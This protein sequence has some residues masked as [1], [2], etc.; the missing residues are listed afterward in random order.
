[1]VTYGGGHV[2]MLVPVIRSLEKNSGY[3]VQ[4]L[5]LTTA[6]LVL[7]RAG[8]P[9][10]GFRHFVEDGDE[11]AL[12]WGERLAKNLDA[13]KVSHEE[14]VAYLGL[15]YMDLIKRL[16]A[17]E[18]EHLYAQR[19]RQ[20][21]C[22]ITVMERILLKIAPDI[23]VATN[24]PRSERA[25]ILAARK[26]GI[27]AVCLVDLFGT[28]EV[29]WIQ[30]KD[31]ADRV[32]VLSETI[33]D[34]FVKSG[35]QPEEVIVTGNPAF[36]RLAQKDLEHKGNEFRAQKGW[37]KDR[38]ILW[39]SQPEPKRH[40]ISQQAGNTNLP[41]KVDQ[42]FFKLLKKHEDWRLVIRPHPSENLSLQDLPDRVEIIP[43][44]EDLHTL[45]MAVDMVVVLTST[46]GL[47][48]ALLGKPFIA[49]NIS[50]Y[51]PDIPYSE[52]GFAKGV[53]QMEDLEEG[54][55]EVLAGRWQ[56][57]ASFPELGHATDNVIKVIEGIL[58]PR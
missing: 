52:W 23:V 4:I 19:E 12:E 14:S 25:A 43:L 58:F 26:L 1:M 49:L 31:Y 51:S 17:E 36:D 7:E 5:G 18:A 44:T 24:S 29:A 10:L 54:L 56:T 6:G 39:A 37:G 21:F 47:E 41:R 53:D 50:V 20:A 9:Y 34:F 40:F 13:G 35:R 16:G 33:K 22:P 3:Q 28:L 42:E 55:I 30:D 38:V 48:A 11:Q 32:C 2:N 8:I 15:S 45:I 46:V 27:P 57:T